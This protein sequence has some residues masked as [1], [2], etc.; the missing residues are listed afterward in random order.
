MKPSESFIE[1]PVRD[2]Q[3]MLR[4]IA[5]NNPRLPTVIPDGIYSPSTGN[6]VAA[7]QR[8]AGLPVTGVTDQVT[9]DI[10]QELYD[11][12]ITQY[13]KAQPIEILINSGQVF[14][15]GDSDPYIYLMQSMLTQLSKDHPS[16]P[17]PPHS[18]IIDSETAE[19]I[20]AFQLLAQLPVTRTLDRKTWKHIVLHFTA[21]VHHNYA[22]NN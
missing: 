4:I 17:Q 22:L 6:A 13:G 5:K 18:G 2:L 11:E 14:Q 19:S 21:N 12:A 16:I 20:G 8:Q 9:W 3:T 7:L 1:Q 15:L 10:I